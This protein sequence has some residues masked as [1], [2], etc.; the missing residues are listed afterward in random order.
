VTLKGAKGLGLIGIGRSYVDAPPKE[1][2]V[3]VY[4]HTAQVSILIRKSAL[5]VYLNY[6]LFETTL[7]KKA[8]S[9]RLGF[10]T[11]CPTP[12]ADLSAV[13]GDSGAIYIRTVRRS[14]DQARLARWTKTHSVLLA[15]R[16]VRCVILVRSS[17]PPV[18]YPF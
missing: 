6:D 18:L 12:S 4:R 13:V 14:L 16:L 10:C 17:D 7:L 2:Y 8:V 5:N 3:T 15:L 1:P 11:C 9:Q